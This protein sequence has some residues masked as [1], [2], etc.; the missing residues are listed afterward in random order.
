MK[1]IQWAVLAAAVVMALPRPAGA[2]E[3]PEQVAERYLS[4]MKARDWAANAAL[5]H[6][7]ELDSLKAAFVDVAHSDTSSA[8]LR[9]LFAVSTAREL[10][11]LTPVQVYQRFVASTVGEQAEMTQFLAS[12]VFKVLGHVAE[13]DSVYVVYRVSA[14]GSA[15]PMS[16]VTV[17]SLRRSGSGWK[18][19]L[20]DELRGTMVAL[21]TQAAQ[22]RASNAALTPPSERPTPRP[23]P[24]A[25]PAPPVVPPRP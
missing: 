18:T 1:T 6:P 13:G 24:P 19:R 22:R 2:Q 10:E 21:H 8:G 16:Q 20:T 11:A 3:T 14:I 12:A 4:T 15:G 25:A 9:A 23:A 17:M 7:E 5:V